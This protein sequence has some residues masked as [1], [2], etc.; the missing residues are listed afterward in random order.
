MNRSLSNIWLKLHVLCPQDNDS[1]VK[2]RCSYNFLDF[3]DLIFSCGIFVGIFFNGMINF[4]MM[5]CWIFHFYLFWW[6]INFL[7]DIELIIFII[8]RWKT[9]VILPR[10][11]RCLSHPDVM[12]AK[13]KRKSVKSERLRESLLGYL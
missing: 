10:P 3:F 13:I 2:L 12:H 6:L 9:W 8:N 5:N 7:Y 1:M 11:F 4:R